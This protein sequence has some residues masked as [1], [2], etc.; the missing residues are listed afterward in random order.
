[1]LSGGAVSPAL[2][3][4]FTVSV[5][6]EVKMCAAVDITT[7]QSAAIVGSGVEDPGVVRYRYSKMGRSCLK[8][9]IVDVS[10]DGREEYAEHEAGECRWYPFVPSADERAAVRRLIAAGETHDPWPL[11][12]PIEDPSHVPEH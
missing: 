8:Y 2:S 7:P 6:E 5:E 3:C 12:I 9:V 10:R 4:K 1:M 11:I